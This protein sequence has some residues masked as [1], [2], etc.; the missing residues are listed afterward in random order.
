MVTIVRIDQTAVQRL[1]TRVSST[2]ALKAATK[3]QGRVQANMREKQRIRTGRMVT[4]VNVH[5]VKIGSSSTYSVSSDVPYVGFQEDG[6][7]PVFARPGG[8]LR[9]QPKGSA[10]FIFRPRTKGFPGGHF[11]RDA[12][13]D[14]K[15]SDFL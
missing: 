2:A 10:V 14:I 1:L 11:F 7:G 15:L 3:T 5:A 8:V 12:Q 4:S 6:I 9:F 13:R